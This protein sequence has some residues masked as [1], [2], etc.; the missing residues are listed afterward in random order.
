MR[1]ISFARREL[2]FSKSAVPPQPRAIVA[3][4]H[5]GLYK[6]VV[7]LRKGNLTITLKI[8]PLC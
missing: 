3:V 1:G 5:G 4:E 6:D 8:P 7:R 2:S